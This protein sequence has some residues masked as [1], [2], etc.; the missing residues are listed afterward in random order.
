MKSEEN[1]KKKMEAESTASKNNYDT[2]IQA[3]SA[4]DLTGLIPANPESD[5]ELESYEELYPFIPQAK[6]KK[7]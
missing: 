1:D 5:E 6:N 7:S 2:D 4:T 3:C